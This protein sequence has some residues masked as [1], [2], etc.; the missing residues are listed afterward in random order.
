MSGRRHPRGGRQ[1]TAAAR[2]PRRAGRHERF[3]LRH[4]PLPGWASARCAASRNAS[5]CP[6][7]ASESSSPV[8]IPCS[9]LPHHVAP[10]PGIYTA[11]VANWAARG[12]P[13]SRCRG[14]M[15]YRPPGRSERRIVPQHPGTTLGC[16]WV[17]GGETQ[18]PCRETGTW[19]V[20]VRVL[21]AG[22]D[23]GLAGSGDVA[24]AAVAAGGDAGCRG[25]GGNGGVLR[26]R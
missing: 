1:E 4:V 18:L 13:V 22:V 14:Y 17:V 25:R 2:R 26:C 8:T 9:F 19:G 12:R 16:A 21:R 10:P 11:H 15:H 6:A 24:G 23:G 5:P 3:E 7:R 20:A